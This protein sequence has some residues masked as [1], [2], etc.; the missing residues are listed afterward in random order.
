M[1]AIAVP[2][3][4]HRRPPR[5]VMPGFGLTLG[6]T[7]FYLCLIVLIPLAGVFVKAAGLGLDGI[8]QVVSSPRVSL[9]RQTVAV[10]PDVC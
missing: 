6:Y 10:V 2:H 5:S 1:T 7:I 4:R 3:P 8:W 9:I